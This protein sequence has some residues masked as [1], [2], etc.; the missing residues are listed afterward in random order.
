[1]M[2]PPDAL[3]LHLM[4][5]MMKSASFPSGFQPWSGNWSSFGSGWK[6]PYLPKSP[7][8]K[9]TEALQQSLQSLSEQLSEGASEWA[10]AWSAGLSPDASQESDVSS[11]PSEAR[12]GISRHTDGAS[13]RGS[14]DEPGMTDLLDFFPHFFQPAFLTALAEES[15]KQTSGFIEGVTAYLNSDYKR[16]EPNY[17][18]IWKRGAARLLDLAPEN[19][20]GLAVLCIPSLINKFYVLDLYPEASF[21]QYLKKQGFR[22]LILDWGTPS[23]TEK[24]FTCADYITSHALD[25]LQTLRE[26][27]DGPIA[28]LGYC[29]GGIFATAMAQLAPMFVDALILLATPWDFS[30][31]DT[32]RVLLEPTSQTMLRQWI[33][34][35]NPVPPV[36]TQT[37]FHLINPWYVQEKYRDFLTLDEGQRKHFLAIEQWVNDGVPIPQKAAEE[38]FVDWPQGNILA[39]HKWKVG[40]KWIEPGSITCPTLAVIPQRDLI[41]P[42]GVAQPLADAMPRADVIYPE[43]GHVGMVAGR[44]AEKVL[45]EPVSEWL[46]EK[47]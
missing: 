6:N 31:K 36:V 25:A 18:V 33:R 13:G 44:R 8:E 34:G 42:K 16:P 32:P 45:W 23:E 47:F 15:F 30:A 19:T 11:R 14:R 43:A 38:C 39:T 4:L 41:V 2:T 7:L 5:S 9:S 24:D 10:N 3:P 46:G 35:L 26:A 40:R 17:K 22:P 37:L 21:A 29:M 20:D 12:A 27:H 28:L 1:M